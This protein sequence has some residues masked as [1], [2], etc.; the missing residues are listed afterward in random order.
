MTVSAPAAAGPQDADWEV[1][2]YSRPVLEPD[3]RKRW[4]LLICATPPVAA[5][6]APGAAE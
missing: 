4:E 3:G 6:G 2:F 1:D 5:A